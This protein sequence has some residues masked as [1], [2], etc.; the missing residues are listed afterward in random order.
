MQRLIFSCGFFIFFLIT[1]WVNAQIEFRAIPRIEEN[2]E[3]ARIKDTEDIPLLLPFWDDFSWVKDV[4]DTALWT[5]GNSVTISNYAG[6]NAPTINVATFNGVDAFGRPYANSQETGLTDVLVS[7]SID[8]ST[9]T[10]TQA[11]SVYLSF[12][13]QARGLGDK[14]NP[15]DSIRLQFK[16][17]DDRW[18]TIWSQINDV[19]ANNEIQFNQ[20]IFQITDQGLG[21]E[22]TYFH[23]RFQFRYQA[24]GNQGGDY[25]NWH[26]DYVYLNHS[27]N[28][29]DI[30][31][32]DEALTTPPTALFTPYYTIPF[33]VLVN[34]PQKY[35][36]KPVVQY[37]NLTDIA[38]SPKVHAAVNVLH[39]DNYVFLDSLLGGYTLNPLPEPGIF[40]WID[41]INELDHQGIL[42]FP[43]SIRL[44]LETKVFLTSN[45][46]VF[47]QMNLLRND[48]VRSYVT[49]DNYYAYDDG[50]AEISMGIGKRG[51]KLAYMY[52]L[53]E[54]DTLTDIDIYFP[55]FSH[56]PSST[57]IIMH[58]WD[59][60]DS[61]NPLYRETFSIQRASRLNEL[62]RY[63]LST[64][65]V[66]RD[67]FYIGY[68]QNIDEY[69]TIGYDRN[70]DSS[71]K[72]YYY[73]NLQDGWKKYSDSAP[74]TFHQGS[75]MMRPVFRA[76]NVTNVKTPGQKL[77]INLFP[78][79]SNGIIYISGD[80]N[81]MQVKVSDTYGRLL[82]ET[83]SD[84][85]N[86][87][88]YPAGVY[89][90]QIATNKGTVTRKVI[91]TK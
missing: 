71:D 86:L 58:V 46:P 26:I 51:G 91:L 38:T 11:V 19:E 42:S 67:T 39:N 1:G 77:K 13:W 40:R 41:Q 21:A 57:T 4:P 85:V 62:S 79:P 60:L 18:I 8:L 23:E 37:H 74:S 80:I 72:I 53:E 30:S 64:P 43:D 44:T 68:E 3:N 66:V 45:D 34:N 63:K 9:L 56:I 22:E 14:P 2:A 88:N 17:S 36:N 35:L 90:F 5:V 32:E 78:N 50:F 20:E 27:R 75:L 28:A 48:T 89:L 59:D 31:Y 61:T 76:T 6:L 55:N 24:F 82:M 84:M 54:Q 70:H 83:S 73:V 33:K 52:V 29:T 12:F 16:S 10:T 15:K 69:L 81:P 65:V 49:L 7:R 25:D 87:S 47:E